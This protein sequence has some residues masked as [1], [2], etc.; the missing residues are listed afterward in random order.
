VDK[1][2]YLLELCRYI[3][4][5]TVRVTRGTT[6]PLGNGALTRHQNGIRPVLPRRLFR[7]PEKFR[8]M[9]FPPLGSTGGTV[10]SGFFAGGN[11]DIA[12][13]RDALDLS[14]HNAQFGWISFVIG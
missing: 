8:Q 2:A 12:A 14:L 9:M 10:T 6:R 11:Q 3:V 1:E 5:N 7:R 13:L 4:L